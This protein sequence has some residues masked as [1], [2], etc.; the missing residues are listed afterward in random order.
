MYEFC[1]GKNDWWDSGTVDVP[2]IRGGRWGE[3]LD[4]VAV[5]RQ[6]TDMS[7]S[8]KG[9]SMGLRVTKFYK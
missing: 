2:V 3:N 4:G 7:L 6:K 8:H 1:D 9:P 5:G